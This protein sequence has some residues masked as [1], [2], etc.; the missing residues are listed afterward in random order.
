MRVD[1]RTGY[2]GGP[3][4]PHHEDLAALEEEH[5]PGLLVGGGSTT[6]STQARVCEERA[7]HTVRACAVVV[8]APRMTTEGVRRKA[9]RQRA[10]VLRRSVP[11]FL[12]F[13]SI[14]FIKKYAILTKTPFGFDGPTLPKHSFTWRVTAPLPAIVML[15]PR[16][17]TALR[18]CA[19]WDY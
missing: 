2:E 9:Y 5:A 17:R 11:P 18:R 16:A 15:Q 12:T 7:S 4:A 1:V 3:P 13:K 19:L 8:R 6:H 10:R 14:T